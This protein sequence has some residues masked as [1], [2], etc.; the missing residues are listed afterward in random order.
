[1]SYEFCHE[2]EH[3]RYRQV[4]R[5]SW[6]T[7]AAYMRLGGDEL[8][9]AVLHPMDGAYDCLSL[10]D[11]TG[12][13]KVM[14][15]RNGNAA[16]VGGAIV[17]H[18]WS[19]AA[20]GTYGPLHL[21]V[22]LLERA[23]ALPPGAFDAEEVPPANLITRSVMNLAAWLDADRS[24]HRHVLWGLD[25]D[26]WSA[27]DVPRR[28]LLSRFEPAPWVT[29]MEPWPASGAEANLFVLVDSGSPVALVDVQSSQAV[30][31]QGREWS[32][33]PPDRHL[34]RKVREGQLTSVLDLV[35]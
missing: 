13:V 2:G 3:R 22:R 29:G 14:L 15:N 17:P 7:V 1:M 18:I 8:H 31:P 28:D 32:Q 20:A 23:H 19:L 6:L 9:P 21:A 33:W 12:T 27:S 5:L 34:L 25:Y 4:E 35:R 30:D 11:R 10:V 24:G 16:S 26:Y